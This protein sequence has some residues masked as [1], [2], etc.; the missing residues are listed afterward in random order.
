MDGFSIH[1]KYNP[2]QESD[3]FYSSN[4]PFPGDIQ[5]FGGGGLYIL[6]SILKFK[7][8]PKRID[9][10]E[11]FEDLKENDTLKKKF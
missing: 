11:P 6:E 10:Y 7:P 3:R 4:L 8:Y 9:L 2:E 5:I 1:S